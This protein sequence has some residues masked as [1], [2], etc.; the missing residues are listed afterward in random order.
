MSQIRTAVAALI[1]S[2]GLIS[3]F[4]LPRSFVEHF[5][6]K[7]PAVNVLVCMPWVG[8]L[9]GF[10]VFLAGVLIRGIF[11][12]SA[13]ALFFALA[14][15]L[16]FFLKDSGRGFSLLLSYAGKRFSGEPPVSALNRADSRLTELL[17]NPVMLLVAVIIVVLV[18]GMLFMLFFRGAGF[19]LAAVIGADAL[20]QARLCLEPDRNTRMAFLHTAGKGKS[21]LGTSAVLAALL[22]LICFPAVAALGAIVILWVWFWRELPGSGEFQDGWSADWITMYGFGG[23]LITLLCGMGLL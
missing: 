15:P 22:M 19:W 3:D 13:G 4:Q 16:L 12:P 21:R 10:L 17:K 2:W 6:M 20:I 1:A 18:L 9:A 7:V 8:M 23:S 5:R 14:G 11:N